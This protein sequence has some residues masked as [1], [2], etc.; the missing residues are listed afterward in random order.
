MEVRISAFKAEGRVTV[1]G[2]KSYTQRALAAALLAGGESLIENPSF[3]DDAIHAV[4][5]VKQLGGT[6]RA[7]GKDIVAGGPFSPA[8]SM[9]ECG[10]SGLAIRL[11]TPVAALHSETLTLRASGTLTRRSMEMM[12]EPLRMLGAG[13]KTSDG[14]P[15]VQVHGPL[16]GGKATVDGSQS[17]QFLSGLLMA[18]PMTEND[19][20]LLVLQLKSRPYIDMSLGLIRH[21]GVNIDHE[22]YEVFRIAG[23]Q[24]YRPATYRVE[25]DWSGAAFLLV[26]GALGGPVEVQGLNSMSLQADRAIVDILEEAG[27]VLR[28]VPGGLAVSSGRLNA[29]A[30]DATDCPDLFPPLIPLAAHARGISRIRG[31]SR[32]WGKESNRAEVLQ[33]EFARLGVSIG[34][35]DDEMLIEGGNLKA[36]RIDPH[37]DHR[38]AMAAAVMPAG[39]CPEVIISNPE[40]VKKS[41]PS[42][43]DDLTKLGGNIQ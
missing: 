11:F 36:G 4:E 1:P 6:V 16:R 2:S 18:L 9:L 38:I 35:E 10:E 26:A 43:F 42:F 23:K 40:C 39:I 14:F 15:P 24:Q 19:S 20:E 41:Y 29:F 13:C 17:S 34:V 37:G 21:F 31:V 8:G 28:W 7:A 22:N 25:G 33:K 32:L 3:S 5:L 27:A 30:A 12:E